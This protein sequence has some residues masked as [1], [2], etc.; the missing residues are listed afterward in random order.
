MPAF[1]EPRQELN[2]SDGKQGA[3]LHEPQ[4]VPGIPLARYHLDST[5]DEMFRESGSR[6]PSVQSAPATSRAYG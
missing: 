2:Q 4:G 3:K 6:A 1:N 5:Y